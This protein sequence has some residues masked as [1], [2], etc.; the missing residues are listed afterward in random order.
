MAEKSAHIADELLLL[1]ADHELSWRDVIRVRSHLALCSACRAR[2]A[3]MQD[4]LIEVTEAHRQVGGPIAHLSGP[5]ALLKARLAELTRV[6]ACPSKQLRFARSLAYLCALALL[7]AIGA[8][9]SRQYSRSHSN[10]D[11]GMLPDP[12]FT[13]GSTRQVSL[14]EICSA[15]RDEVIRNVS[16]LVQQKVFQE[17]GIKDQPST[18]FEVDYLITPGLGGSDDVRNLWPEPHSSTAW[19]SY[20]KDQ[21]E[22]HLHRMV[23]GG[24]LSLGDAQRDIATNWIAAYKKYFHTDRPLSTAQ[25]AGSSDLEL[26]SYTGLNLRTARTPSTT[27]S[28]ITVN[29]AIANGGS[30][31]MGASACSAGTLRKDWTTA[32]KILKYSAIMALTT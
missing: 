23:C 21:L 20:V 24:K 5:R 6:S 16:G 19:N 27:N 15:D 18:D 13:P 12:G 8:G 31:P 4:T 11:F 2:M 25:L 9:V 1:H 32:T 3:H 29:C 26:A 10:T 7:T 14:A 22:D 17:Y 28:A 30:F